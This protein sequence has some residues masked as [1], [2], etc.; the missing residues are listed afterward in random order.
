MR[1]TLLY[2]CIIFSTSAFAQL[3]SNA[4]CK[5]CHPAI[6]KEYKTSAH[7]KST[8]YKDAIHKAIW[9]M[10]PEKKKDKYSCAK[11]HTPADTRIL[12]ALKEGTEA[13]PQDDELH[14]E[15][16]S[17]ITCHSVK[18]ITS[19][20]E[21]HDEIVLVDNDRKRP[22]IFAANKNNRNDKGL[23]ERTRYTLTKQEGMFKCKS[24]SPY[25]DINYTNEIFYNGKMCL[26]CHQ[27]MENKLGQNICTTEKEGAMDEESN[28]VT[29][30]MPKIE[31]SFATV[32]LSKTHRFHGF[33]GTRNRP[34]LLAKYLKINFKKTLSGFEITLKNEAKHNLLLHPLRLGKL[35]VSI[36]NGTTTEELKS[37]SFFRI[38]G[39]EGK[40]AMPWM[41][42][43]VYKDNMLKA[44]EVRTLKYDTEVN[45]GDIVEVKFG[46]YLVNP[47]M[48]KKLN[49][50]D[51]EEATK[52]NILKTESFTVE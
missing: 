22:V 47:K 14:H 50:M 36:K 7:S 19:H 2:L 48:L 24:R 46:Y 34:D 1:I 11:C 3:T 40:P 13:M 20:P 23:Y 12:K 52:Y 21:S 41:A 39:A 17:C 9:D 4:T 43:E 15:A 25:H 32:Q 30:H 10:H 49:L 44:D 45:S 18:G 31:G 35:D 27:H 16:I 29:C 6:Y 8:I 26:G 51:N 37:I 38:L 28:C 42:T 33:A 5:M